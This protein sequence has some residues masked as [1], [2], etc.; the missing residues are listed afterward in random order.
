MQLPFSHLRVQ[1]VAKLSTCPRDTRTDT[2]TQTQRIST[3][4]VT[5]T[6]TAKVLPSAAP[7]QGAINKT[8]TT[9]A[10]RHIPPS[11]GR[12]RRSVVWAS[13]AGTHTHSPAHA[14]LQLPQVQQSPSVP[15]APLLGPWPSHLSHSYLLATWSSS[16]TCST[17]TH[18]PWVPHIHKSPWTYQHGPPTCLLPQPG[19]EAPLLTGWSSFTFAGERIR[20]HHTH[21][22]WGRQRCSTPPSSRH[23]AHRLLILVPLQPLALSPSLTSL[24]PVSPSSWFWEHTPKCL[25]AKDLSW[26]Q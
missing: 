15:P 8:C 2:E 21:Q 24:T 11:S 12:D 20:V 10:D 22:G 23:Q 3:W 6:A 13:S 16:Q 25:E 14:H 17:H 7:T 1:P 5:G 19:P 4:V 26:L 9:R 18:I